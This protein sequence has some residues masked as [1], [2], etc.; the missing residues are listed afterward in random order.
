[1]TSL[2]SLAHPDMMYTTSSTSPSDD[3]G[4]EKL[5]Q[6]QLVVI[7]NG[8]PALLPKYRQIFDMPF[9]MYTDPSLALYMA[10]GMGRDL[11]R[12]A[13]SVAPSPGRSVDRPRWRT[14]ES[15]AETDWMEPKKVM[16]DGGYVQ[17]GLVGGIAM[18]VGRALK[19]GMP[20]WGKGGDIAQLGGEFVFGPG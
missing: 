1:M 17:R 20:V 8:A 4:S 18:V 9:S 5:E 19:A 3:E 12:K 11:G 15:I 2:T 7:S 16:L 13:P 14:E 6:V 10:L